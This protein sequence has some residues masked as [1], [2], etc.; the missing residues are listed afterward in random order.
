M[1]RTKMTAK[2]Q[3]TLPKDLRTKLGLKTGDYLQVKRKNWTNKDFK[4]I[5]VC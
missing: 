1:Y 5:P 3:V 4:N 2:G